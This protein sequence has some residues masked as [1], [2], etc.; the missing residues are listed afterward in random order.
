[1]A[2]IVWLFV[3]GAFWH[4]WIFSSYCYIAHIFHHIA[5]NSWLSQTFNVFQLLE[6]IELLLTK[7]G[8]SHCG[9]GLLVGLKMVEW[10]THF[11]MLLGFFQYFGI[12]LDS[13]NLFWK[14]LMFST[15]YDQFGN[16]W[17]V[18]VFLNSG[19]FFL[20]TW[21]WKDKNSFLNTGALFLTFWYFL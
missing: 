18:S 7:V 12:F 19:W 4:L 3:K 10:K 17:I 21:I 11:S 15:C 9:W 8:V 2:D 13:T 20:Y 5:R 1:M 6:P 14:L 16:F